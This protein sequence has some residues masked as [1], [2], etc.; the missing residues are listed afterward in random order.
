[1]NT[2]GETLRVQEDR[3]QPLGREGD[4]EMKVLKRI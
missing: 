3:D 4:G 2:A 1:M